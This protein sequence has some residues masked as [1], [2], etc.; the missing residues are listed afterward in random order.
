M[1]SAPKN[2]IKIVDHI[3]TLQQN[4]WK[5]V[6]SDKFLN[7]FKTITTT[8]EQPVNVSELQKSPPRNTKAVRVIP[9][10]IRVKHD[11]T[12]SLSEFWTIQI[13][14]L[15]CDQINCHQH[16]ESGRVS[17]LEGP[18][19]QAFSLCDR[20]VSDDNS[21]TNLCFLFFQSV[22]HINSENYSNYM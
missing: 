3:L 19:I 5:L 13:F 12:R 16:R 2:S 9:I 15:H 7:T 18:A 8:P 6:G 4:S 11:V 17:L 20:K 21:V 14:Y 22:V 10:T 1:F